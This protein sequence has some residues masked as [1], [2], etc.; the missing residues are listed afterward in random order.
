MT[1]YSER[2]G[3]NYQ[4]EDW[5]FRDEAASVISTNSAHYVVPRH[6]NDYVRRGIL[7]PQVVAPTIRLYQYYEV[8]NLVVKSRVG[9]RPL[10]DPSPGAMRVRRHRL[11]K[12]MSHREF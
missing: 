11:K 3:R 2:L 9:R 10:E 7:H 5:L 8:K 4:D 1:H 12:V 6:L